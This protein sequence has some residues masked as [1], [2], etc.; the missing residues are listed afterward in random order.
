MEAYRTIEGRAEG[1][2]E[3]RKSRFIG[4]VEPATTEQEALDFLARVRAEHP[5]ARHHVYAYILRAGNRVR[6]S[7]DGEPKRTA[8]IPV[9]EVLQH[10]GVSD[11]AC[12]V[13]RYFGGTLLGTG[14]LVRAYTKA[15]QLALAHA[16]VVEL[17]P[18]RDVMVAVPYALYDQV[19][20]RLAEERR[21]VV[22]TVYADDVTVQVRVLANEAE[23]FA[24]QLTD[25]TNGRAEILIG[26]EQMAYVDAGEHAGAPAPQG[27]AGQKDS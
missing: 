26:D 16:H 12:A 22:D 10:A 14:G 25:F 23:R 24:A 6:Y 9:L 18:C 7:D 19:A 5:M 4:I 27:D 3:D 20:H 13:V 2:Y 15:P 1:E 11:V 17:A 8:G 21:T